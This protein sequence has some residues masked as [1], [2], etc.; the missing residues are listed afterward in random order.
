M[1]RKIWIAWL[2]FGALHGACSGQKTPG[3]C[4]FTPTAKRSEF[5]ASGEWK[6]GRKY[7]PGL[8]RATLLVGV[9][10]FFLYL[11]H[12]HENLRLLPEHCEP[13]NS[14]TQ[15]EIYP[16]LSRDGKVAAYAAMRWGPGDKVAITT[17][18]LVDHKRTVWAEGAYDGD[19]AISPDASK[20]AFFNRKN[21]NHIEGDNHLHII[22]L[23]TGQETLGPE[24][25]V[26]AP[27]DASWSP[28]SRLLAYDVLGELRVWDAE[29]GAVT[30]IAEGGASVPA[31]SPSGE[32]IAYF[33]RRIN[34][35]PTCQKVPAYSG[36]SEVAVVHPDGTGRR[37]LFSELGTPDQQ[38]HLFLF[39]R[40]VWSPDSQSILIN[41]LRR[42]E[43]GTV[44]IYLFDLK[45]LKL[46]KIFQHT[47][48]V[49]GWVEER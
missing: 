17:Y 45:T 42:D 27:V 40:P 2:V 11:A 25:P 3:R 39:D 21:K 47:T 24:A 30:K 16:S 10:P 35:D 22:D 6:R 48:E 34:A 43:D 26:C 41:H 23:K 20:L 46:K 4:D 15:P 14:G 12:E 29:T 37:T 13:S 5:P 38:I 32:W 33:W 28:D 44:D 8:P 36:H 7:M 18:S 9:P 19:V 49:W 31:W 1:W